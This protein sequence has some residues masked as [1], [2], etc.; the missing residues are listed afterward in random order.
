MAN[1]NDGRVADRCSS[2]PVTT[3]GVTFDPNQAPKDQYRKARG[4]GN[5]ALMYASKDEVQYAL[6]TGREIEAVMEANRRGMLADR[7]ARGATGYVKAAKELGRK[8]IWSGDDHATEDAQQEDGPSSESERRQQVDEDHGGPSRAKGKTEVDR[9]LMERLGITAEVDEDALREAAEKA[10]KDAVEDAKEGIADEIKEQVI[11]PIVIEMPEDQ[12]LEP[13]VIECPHEALEECDR[14]LRTHGQ[15]WMVG[16]TGS[17]KSHI[18]RDLCK[19]RGIGPD[20]YR[21]IGCA[22]TTDIYDLQGIEGPDGDFRRHAMAECYEEGYPCLLDE[23]DN[24]DPSTGVACNQA[25]DGGPVWTCLQRTHD[26][27]MVRHQSFMPV[28]ATNTDGSGATAGY[29]GRQKIDAA[30]LSRFPAVTRVYVDYSMKVERAILAESQALADWYWQ[31]RNQV[32]ELGLAEERLPTTRDFISAAREIKARESGHGL[33]DWA[34]KGRFLKTWSE[35]ER[36]S[37]PT[38]LVSGV[39]L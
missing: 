11:Q 8:P 31:V 9:E 37:L 15:L 16:P 21:I 13:I 29:N 27:V 6:E 28:I 20:K 1:H 30:V 19:M 18:F 23:Y 34:I 32:R 10:A 25:L 33:D 22:A 12:G 38:S 14:V 36:D 5:A 35:D 26:P 24:L 7:Q 2:V 4:R 17:G 39:T 3:E